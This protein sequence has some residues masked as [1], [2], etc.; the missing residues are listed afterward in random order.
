MTFISDTSHI[1]H[2]LGVEMRLYYRQ[3]MPG[4]RRVFG[5]DPAGLWRGRLVLLW[6]SLRKHSWTD[7]EPGIPAMCLKPDRQRE[8]A[9]LR[10]RGLWFSCLLFCFLTSA[11]LNGSFPSCMFFSYFFLAH[12][13]TQNI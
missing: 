11:R 1:S 9:A 3:S 12:T 4:L 6:D 8:V 13:H 5:G 2:A 10:W 7:P